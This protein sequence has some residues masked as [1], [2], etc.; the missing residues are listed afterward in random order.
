MRIAVLFYGRINKF[1]EHRENILNS[2]GNNILD[3]FYS[4]D[5]SPQEDIDEFINLYK[6][7]KVTNA[8]IHFKMEFGNYPKHP[9]THVDRMICH[10]VNKMRVFHLME[11]HAKNENINYDA[12]ISLR[13][14]LL[15]ESPFTINKIEENTI[16]IPEG[17]D[18]EPDAI[19]DQIAYGS[20]ETMKKYM[21][22]IYN[23]EFII[24]NQLSILHPESLTLTNLMINKVKIERFHLRYILNK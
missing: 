10:F 22:I 21:N 5:N 8:K 16:Y 20:M 14:D 24:E 19:N 4:S 12:V 11:T 18:F 3:I 17:N 7:V 23:L 6:P 13:L 2:L 1:R 15:I 9:N